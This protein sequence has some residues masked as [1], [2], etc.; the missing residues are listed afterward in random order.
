MGTLTVRNLDDDVQ[1]RIRRRA[2]ENGRSMEAEARAILSAAVSDNR[3]VATWL[4]AVA[5][6]G[7]DEFAV[8]PR[9]APRQSDLA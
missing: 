7:L 5:D 3:L 4:A 2:A 9:S 6:I 8:P 1:R